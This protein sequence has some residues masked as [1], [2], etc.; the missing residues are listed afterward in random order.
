MK[1]ILLLATLSM[2]V[3]ALIFAPAALAHTAPTSGTAAAAQYQ[4]KKTAAPAAA[5]YQYKKIATPAAAQYQYK[6]TVTPLPSTGGPGPYGNGV[7]ALGAGALLVGGGL[8]ARRI[9]R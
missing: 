9:F 6:K 5:Q 1:R 3:G 2:F 8:V 4:Y 7:L